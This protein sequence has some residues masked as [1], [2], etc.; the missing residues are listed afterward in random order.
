MNFSNFD[1]HSKLLAV[2]TFK[3]LLYKYYLKFIKAYKIQSNSS[4]NRLT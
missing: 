2:K 4:L 3:H 1:N